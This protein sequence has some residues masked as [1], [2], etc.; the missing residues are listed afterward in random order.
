MMEPCLVTAL[1]F[2]VLSVNEKF[3]AGGRPVQINRA[4]NLR[5]D[6]SNQACTA[7]VLSI[8]TL[9]HGKPLIKLINPFGGDIALGVKI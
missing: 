7:G 9:H 4:V 5:T 8:C 2:P 6:F 3:S 1:V